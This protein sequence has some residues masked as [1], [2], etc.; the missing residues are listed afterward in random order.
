MVIRR[1]GGATRGG[2]ER[3]RRGTELGPK[4]DREGEEGPTLSTLCDERGGRWCGGMVGQKPARTRGA[5][6]L[7]VTEARMGSARPAP[8]G[9]RADTRTS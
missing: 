3:G 8:R 9:R 5:L 2:L 6:T 1:G 7:C 4:R